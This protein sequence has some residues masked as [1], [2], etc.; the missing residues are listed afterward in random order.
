MALGGSACLSAP[1]GYLKCVSDALGA[2]ESGLTNEGLESLQEAVAFNANDSLAHA[3]LGV[4]LLSGGLADD[5]MA[6]FELACKL[7]GGCAEA[8][9]GRGLVY[10]SKCELNR[11][12]ACF[13][14]AQEANGDLNVRPAIEYV[15]SL[16]SGSYGGVEDNVHDESLQALGAL[17]LM[18]EG[19]HSEAAAIWLALQHKAARP[20][21]GERIGCT[22][23]F[24]DN[25]PVALTGWPIRTR[26]TSTVDDEKNSNVVSGK[27]T[28]KADLRAAQGVDMVAF[29]V[30]NKLVGM[31]NYRPYRYSWDTS[32]AANGAHTIRIAGTDSDGNVISEKST[33]VVVRN[34]DLSSPSPRVSGEEAAQVWQRLWDAL[35]LKPSAAAI[36]Y[37]LALCAMEHK[38]T[39]TATAALE[40]VMAADPGYM[41]AADRL[42][43]LYGA[44]NTYVRLHKVRSDAKVIALTFDDGPKEHTAKLLDVL[45]EKG[46]KATF[47]VVGKQAQAFPEMVKWIAAEGHEVQNHTYTHRD[48]EYLS[49]DQIKREVFRTAAV[50]R[51]L[52]GKPG[53]FLRPPGGHEGRK[54]PGIM[55]KFGMTTVLWTTNCSKM[56]GTTRERVF[57]H[58]VGSAEAGGIV[59]MHN[60]EPVTLLALPDIID[61][62]RGRGYRFV[63][64][65]ELVEGE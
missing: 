35:R 19:R 40:R 50:V 48:L 21:F 59:L 9:Y 43:E 41:D 44:N 53:R 34:A 27:V 20:G 32:R 28:L 63:T 16:V 39:E 51:S 58:V 14:E 24:L 2:L 17:G 26:Y 64:V 13:R 33:T 45:K 37:N 54:L 52:T 61:E 5:A 47:F 46:V 30:D 25:S 55:R 57:N 29:F 1:E 18:N 38:D 8:I 15:N 42:S 4:T 23:T 36:N 60:G 49:D 10:L 56:E 22:M 12:A 3:A 65:S 7:E 31:T 62:L 11:A 6:E